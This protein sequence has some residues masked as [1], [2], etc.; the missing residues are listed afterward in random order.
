M[1]ESRVG[2]WKGRSK[3]REHWSSPQ[4]RKPEFPSVSAAEALILLLN[5]LVEIGV[6]LLTYVLQERSGGSAANG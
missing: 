6:Q 4:D 5:R 2:L 3:G 1:W